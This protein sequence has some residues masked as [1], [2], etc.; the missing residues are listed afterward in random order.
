VLSFL[1]FLSIFIGFIFRDIFIGLGTDFWAN[2]IFTLY[3]HNEILYAEFI[4]YYFKLIPLIF[5]ILGLISS[6]LIYFIL[7]NS[8]LL[9]ITNSLLRSLYFFLIKKWYFDLL[10]N[11]IF[12]FN[13][14]S[15]CY[16]LTFKVIDRGLIEIFGPLSLVRWVSKSSSV[17]S[18]F[19]TGF[20]YNYIFIVL[21]GTI[22]FLKLVFSTSIFSLVSINFSLFLCLLIFTIFLTF[23]EKAK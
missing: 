9:V 4:D 7:Y 6:L 3:T 14:L 2:S 23:F 11:N 12:V 20:L 15:L 10:Y 8:T 22:F 17:F 16:S 13:F 18:F 21:L 19:Q 5:S 1:G